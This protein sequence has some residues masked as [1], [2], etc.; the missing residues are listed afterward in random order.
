[1]DRCGIGGLKCKEVEDDFQV[2]NYRR[3]K[4]MFNKRKNFLR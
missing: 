2:I 3:S 4:N 1:M